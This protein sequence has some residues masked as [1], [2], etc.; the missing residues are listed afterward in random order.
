MRERVD[1]GCRNPFRS[2]AHWRRSPS[3][4]RARAVKR[5]RGVTHSRHAMP[6]ATKLIIAANVVVFLLQSSLGDS[7][8]IWFALWPLDAPAAFG[9]D[10][11][12]AP[13]QLVTYSFLHGGFAH[14]FFNMFGVYT[15]GSTLE[16]F[17]GTR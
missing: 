6:P 10:V 8:I 4:H 5:A 11:G 16:Q 14:I 15:F 1:L 2:A 3:N 7:A 13:W 12:F 9:P 17:F